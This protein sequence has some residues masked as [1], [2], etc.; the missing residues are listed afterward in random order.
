LLPNRLPSDAN[1]LP[2][3]RRLPHSYAM[4]RGRIELPTPRFSVKEP[5]PQIWP[6]L[7]G[8]S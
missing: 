8:L 3:G 7:Q 2:G 1:R 6:W 4:A 5:D